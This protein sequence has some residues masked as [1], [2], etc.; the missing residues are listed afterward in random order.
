MFPITAARR[1]DRRGRRFVQ[2]QPR[3]RPRVSRSFGEP[4]AAITRWV[5]MRAIEPGRVLAP[6]LLLAAATFPTQLHAQV[7]AVSEAEA[8]HAGVLEV[9]VNRSQVLR[10]D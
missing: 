1:C 8:L 10:V 3:G 9:P 2:R 4:R 7:T 5:S 6:L